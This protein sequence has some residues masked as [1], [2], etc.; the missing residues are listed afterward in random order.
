MICCLTQLYG[1]GRRSTRRDRVRPV[2]SGRRGPAEESLG[3]EA[4]AARERAGR[5]A[6]TAAL[7]G[8]RR[9]WPADGRRQEPA[10]QWTAERPATRGRAT[11]PV[12]QM[13]W[14][15]PRGV[16]R[17]PRTCPR[18][19]SSRPGRASRE[20]ARP[21]RA[22]PAWHRPSIRRPVLSPGLLPPC[23]LKRTQSAR[24]GD[25][26]PAT[27]ASCTPPPRVTAAA[28]VPAS[29]A[30]ARPSPP[31]DQRR[32]DAE[33]VVTAGGLD[34]LRAPDGAEVG[35][36]RRPVA[37]RLAPWEIPEQPVLQHGSLP[38]AG[39]KDGRGIGA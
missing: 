27:G 34:A 16:R 28:L 36:P 15:R 31:T 19:W 7:V 37:A 20:P 32:H 18:R 33:R 11:R 8:S 35:G 21:V 30:A 25:H 29:R 13:V 24:A 14:R 22:F 9:S 2:T 39:G 10:G 38:S 23:S 4:G 12:R 26:D 1:L 17:G 5:S 3:A 6:R